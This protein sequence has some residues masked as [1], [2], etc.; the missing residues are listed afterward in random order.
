MAVAGGLKVGV[1]TGT[2]GVRRAAFNGVGTVTVQQG[3]V[4]DNFRP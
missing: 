4:D 1:S 2:A 3:G